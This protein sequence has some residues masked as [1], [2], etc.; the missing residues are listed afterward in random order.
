MVNDWIDLRKNLE[1]KL[2]LENKLNPGETKN[3]M[4]KQE[5]TDL[6]QGSLLYL[7]VS[8]SRSL[9]FPRR[10]GSLNKAAGYNHTSELDPSA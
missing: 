2:I 6:P 7:N 10:K 1:F 9:F 4:Y 8:Q 3:Y 5:G